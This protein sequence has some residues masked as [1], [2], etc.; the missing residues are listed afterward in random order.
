[1]AYNRPN[2][3]VEVRF[4][5]IGE[6]KTLTCVQTHFVWSREQTIVRQILKHITRKACECARARRH[7]IPNKRL[8]FKKITKVLCLKNNY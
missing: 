4:M 3:S 8:E 7:K 2:F 5:E 6:C 1:M